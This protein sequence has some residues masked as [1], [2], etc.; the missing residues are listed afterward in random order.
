MLGKQALEGLQNPTEDSRNILLLHT[1]AAYYIDQFKSMTL[2]GD[3]DYLG[4]A[5]Q[6]I[7]RYTW[8]DVGPRVSVAWTSLPLS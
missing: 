5:T 8:G 2:K 4:L 3:R 1:L 7:N 6:L